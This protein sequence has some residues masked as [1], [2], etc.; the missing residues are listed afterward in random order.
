MRISPLDILQQ[1][2]KIKLKG[3]DPEEVE[4]FLNLI[5]E[6]YK[7][8][9][10]EIGELKQEID[11][12]KKEMNELAA[13]EKVLKEA[14]ISTKKISEQIQVNA[15]NEASNVIKQSEMMSKTIIEQARSEVSKIKNEI[16]K[17]RIYRKQMYTKIESEI[18]LFLNTLT[19]MKET[20]TQEDKVSIISASDLPIKENIK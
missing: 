5:A 19:E 16:E 17:L 10:E 13:R 14:I 11:D 3:Y 15:E 20:A 7:K 12:Q 4:A 1:K 9:N 18:N 6:D 2:F 8:A